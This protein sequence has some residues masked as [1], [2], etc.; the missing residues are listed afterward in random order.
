MVTVSLVLQIAALVV[1]VLAACNVA[2]PR[3][4]LVPLGLALWVASLLIGAI[5]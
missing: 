3:V 2:S 5:R 4:S 1:F